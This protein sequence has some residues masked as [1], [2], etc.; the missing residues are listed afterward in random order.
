VS[1][2]RSEVGE[3][4]ARMKELGSAAAPLLLCAKEVAGQLGV[5]PRT[6]ARLMRAGDIEAFKVG[7]KL[8]RTSQ[9]DVA[10]YVIRQY[11]RYRGPLKESETSVSNPV[12]TPTSLSE[13]YTHEN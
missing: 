13:P 2:R 11:E 4:R 7:A 10:D 8:W 6:V 12:Q 5:S 3:N 9:A 1:R